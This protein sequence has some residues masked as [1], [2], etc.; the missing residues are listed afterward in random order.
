[1]KLAESYSSTSDIFKQNGI[2]EKQIK[3]LIKESDVLDEIQRKLR[4]EVVNIYF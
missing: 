1:M 4:E 3:E 2:L